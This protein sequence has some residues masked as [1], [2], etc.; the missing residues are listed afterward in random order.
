[1]SLALKI[2][3]ATDLIRTV[4]AEGG[5]ACATSSFQADCMALLHLVIAEAPNIPVQFLDTGYH[6]PETYAYRDE[7]TA[8]YNLNLVNL[9]PRQTVPEQEAEFG[10][11]YQSAPDRCCGM[12]K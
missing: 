1:M 5:R 9:L 8:R 10:I 2:D 7:M 12:R 4:L 6:F 3:Q 11:L